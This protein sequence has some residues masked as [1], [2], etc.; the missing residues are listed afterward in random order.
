M[1]CQPGC[2]SNGRYWTSFRDPTTTCRRH[3]DD[4]RPLRVVVPLVLRHQPHRPVS[5]DP[6]SILSRLSSAQSLESWSLRKSRGQFSPQSAV[7]I[8]VARCH[9]KTRPTH[10]PNVR[11]DEPDQHGSRVQDTRPDVPHPWV[12]QSFR[13]SRS[14]LANMT[15][16]PTASEMSAHF[17][18]TVTTG[19]ASTRPRARQARSPS[20]NPLDRVALRKAPAT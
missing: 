12:G 19:T 3:R 14:H 7:R 13:A 20:D 15:S 6:E 4:R 10:S 9:M 1:T 11:L 16:T 8:R 18:S 17:L 5:V 2:G